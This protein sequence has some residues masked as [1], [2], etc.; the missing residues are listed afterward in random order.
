MTTTTETTTADV[1]TAL[2]DLNVSLAWSLVKIARR[3]REQ[4]WLHESQLQDAADAAD[5]P[6]C[7]ICMNPHGL[8][9]RPCCDSHICESHTEDHDKN[10]DDACP[11][12]AAQLREE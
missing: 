7:S 8:T 6:L 9:L 12:F 11:E 3:F 5:R 4:V 10:R 2:W 1:E